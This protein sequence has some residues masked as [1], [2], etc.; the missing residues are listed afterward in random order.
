MEYQ[1]IRWGLTYTSDA[2]RVVVL[3]YDTATSAYV[4]APDGGLPVHRD[5]KVSDTRTAGGT[6]LMVT[7]GK[8][9]G[10][11]IAGPWRLTRIGVTAETARGT[12]TLD[13]VRTS[14]PVTPLWQ[15][16]RW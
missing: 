9:P 1:T 10:F 12:V 7:Y 15:P 13:D 14:E 11:S 2:G 4:L 8:M 3:R 5:I 6:R 16:K